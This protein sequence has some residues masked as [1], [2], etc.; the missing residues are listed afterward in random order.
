MGRWWG[1]GGLGG[2]GGGS[3]LQM[4]VAGEQEAA[5]P[6]AR[7]QWGRAR[8]D[9][10]QRWDG[11]SPWRIFQWAEQMG[12]LNL[13]AEWDEEK[14]ALGL[15]WGRH[16][17]GRGEWERGQGEPT[18]MCAPCE[19]RAS[20]PWEKESCIWPSFLYL[21]FEAPLYAGCLV[22]GS[23]HNLG[24]FC[25]TGKCATACTLSTKESAGFPFFCSRAPEQRWPKI[26]SVW[27]GVYNSVWS[28]WKF[29]LWI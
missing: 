9:R 13:A 10:K 26:Q 7:E 8:V 29:D 27:Q 23:D 20:Y 4:V 18:P 16:R 1:G 11:R 22:V 6:V 14:A 3:Q 25:C 15:R 2:K 21:L 17:G 12:E 24:G 28:Q 5:P 19:P